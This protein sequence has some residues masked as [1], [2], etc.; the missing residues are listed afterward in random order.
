MSSLSLLRDGE[1]PAGV[2][3]ADPIKSLTDIHNKTLHDNAPSQRRFSPVDLAAIERLQTNPLWRWSNKKRDAL[4]QY[5]YGYSIVHA[6]TI[7]DVISNR[8]APPTDPAGISGVAG[9][10]RYRASAELR[11]E[12]L[13]LLKSEL[14]WLAWATAEFVS[15]R[16][17]DKTKLMLQL[18]AAFAQSQLDVG[19][20]QGRVRAI[21][22]DDASPRYQLLKKSILREDEGVGP[23]ITEALKTRDMTKKEFDEWPALAHLRASVSQRLDEATMVGCL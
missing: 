4:S 3:R 9:V 23:I 13:E 18:N 21:N 16:Y 14:W 1:L 22:V 20:W 6:L 7:M 8:I 15:S 12:N 19:D 5:L 11:V 10:A 17:D 2:D